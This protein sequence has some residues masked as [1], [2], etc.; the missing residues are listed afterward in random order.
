MHIWYCIFFIKLQTP[1]KCIKDKFETT[2]LFYRAQYEYVCRAKI[3]NS[4]NTR[5]NKCPNDFYFILKH[6]NKFKEKILNRMSKIS[7]KC[8][9]KNLYPEGNK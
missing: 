3:C 9:H 2:Y 1:A 5:C 8:I 6:M 7:V 4:L